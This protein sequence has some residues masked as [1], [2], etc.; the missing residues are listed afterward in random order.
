MRYRVLAPF[1]AIGT[2]GEHEYIK[3]AGIYKRH[4]NQHTKT[5]I[6]PY[7]VYEIIRN[8]YKQRVGVRV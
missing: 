2:I 4:G 7:K 1:E 8:E 6:V 3:Y 5:L